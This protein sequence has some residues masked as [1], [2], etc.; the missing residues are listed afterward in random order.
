MIGDVPEVVPSLYATNI[1]D[2][3][4]LEPVPTAIQPKL[5]GA[6]M[7]NQMSPLALA[8]KVK[9][10]LTPFLSY[11]KVSVGEASTASSTR[12]DGSEDANTVDARP[13]KLVS[14][15]FYHSVIVSTVRT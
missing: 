7:L 11:M 10:K 2:P 12:D 6:A 8:V 3:S 1:N 15:W 5:F 14:H 13:V 9:V 4:I